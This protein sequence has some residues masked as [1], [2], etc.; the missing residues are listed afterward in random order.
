MWRKIEEECS[1]HIPNIFPFFYSIKKLY[2]TADY[3]YTLPSHRLTTYIIGVFAGYLLR[4]LPKDFRLNTVSGFTFITRLSR[5]L[6]NNINKIKSNN[7]FATIFQTTLYT[8]WTVSTMLFL[9]AFIGPSKMGSIDYKYN[10]IHAAVY[11]AFAPI[12][13]CAFF[14]WVILVQHTNNSNGK[15]RKDN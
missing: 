5:T 15:H 2:E 12:G 11:N 8:G 13:W 9:A 3:S 6:E 14:L 4:N 1:L 7:F 10:P